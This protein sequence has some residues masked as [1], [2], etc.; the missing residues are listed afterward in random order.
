[1]I[2]DSDQNRS[3]PHQ[4]HAPGAEPLLTVFMIGRMKGGEGGEGGGALVV[5]FS[6]P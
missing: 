6:I 5:G 2:C 4:A 3:R 1:L